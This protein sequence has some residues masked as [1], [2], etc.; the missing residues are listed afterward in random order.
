MV[1]WSQSDTAQLRNAGLQNA[2][3]VSKGAGGFD[4]LM[5][6]MLRPDDRLKC[7]CLLAC[8]VACLVGWL[9]GCLVGWLLG[10]LLACLLGFLLGFLV[11]WLLCFA[12]LCF[13]W[14][15]PWGGW[16]VVRLGKMTAYVA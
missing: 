2:R 11:S 8:L 1:L 15:G 7:L 6:G 5:H 12:L 13:A 10:F 4:A 9:V 14:L 3:T 16:W